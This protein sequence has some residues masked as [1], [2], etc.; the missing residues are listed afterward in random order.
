MWASCK[1]L[2]KFVDVNRKCFIDCVLIRSKPREIPRS[3]KPLKQELMNSQWEGDMYSPDIRYGDIGP[4]DFAVDL[5]KLLFK[6]SNT[7]DRLNIAR[8]KERI[9]EE[10]AFKARCPDDETFRSSIPKKEKE[11]LLNK[12]RNITLPLQEIK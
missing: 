7:T 9:R 3:M 5:L 4:I 6:A 10:S 1:E 2:D 8:R 11:L 12:G